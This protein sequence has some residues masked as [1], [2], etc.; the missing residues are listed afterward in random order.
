M[1]IGVLGTGTIAT[2]VVHGIAGDG[3]HITIS[4][5]NAENAAL[6]AAHY[7]NVNIADN[8]TVINQSDV[9]FLGLMPEVATAILPALSFRDGQKVISFIADVPL[10]DI[11]TLVAPAAAPT[12][13][14]P[15]PSIAHGRSVIP[16]IGERTVVDELFGKNCTITTLATQEEMNVLLC[17]QAI[18]S[19]AASMVNVAAQWLHANGIDYEVG[20][21]FLRS[22]IT[23]S[24]EQSTSPALLKALDTPGGYN[25]RLRDHMKNSGMTD[26]LNDGLSI[27]KGED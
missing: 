25:Q 27:L 22:L 10:D 5:R 18:L 14:L 24:L 9:I 26:A 19:P 12:L 3:H 11:N 15:F 16:L 20:E 8:Q 21:Q 6:L 2:A 17:A 7:T 23:T 13:M 4:E 1:K